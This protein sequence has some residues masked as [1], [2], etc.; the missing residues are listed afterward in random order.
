LFRRKYLNS[1]ATAVL[2]HFHPEE[3]VRHDAQ[4]VDLGNNTINPG[5]GSAQ[6]YP[7]TGGKIS[8]VFELIGLIGNR[9]PTDNIL[10][11]FVHADAANGQ[12]AGPISPV[13][14]SH[15]LDRVV[16][17]GRTAGSDRIHARATRGRCCRI[18]DHW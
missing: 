8:R 12:F 13:V 3:T 15:I 7:V 6:R 16:G 10:C 5:N 18:R 17:G 11:R 1:A 4:A 2:L 9:L 14:F